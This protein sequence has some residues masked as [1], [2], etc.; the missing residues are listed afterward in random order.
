M[1]KQSVDK[2]ISDL[3]KKVG[4]AVGVVMELK[5]KDKK[6]QQ[7]KTEIEKRLKN[8]LRRVEELSD[9]KES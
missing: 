5:K 1:R 6:W 7:K 9:E 2:C 4:K 8:L 3:E